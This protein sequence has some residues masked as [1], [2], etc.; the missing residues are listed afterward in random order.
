MV[1]DL[2][3]KPKI[4]VNVE[5]MPT[6]DGR[7]IL[8]DVGG[9]VDDVLVVNQLSAI[10][11]S[12]FDGTKSPSEIA[13]HVSFLVK[14]DI[15]E[16]EV[17]KIIE[18]LDSRGF[19]ETHNFSL[20]KSQKKAEFRALAEKPSKF[21]GKSFPAG[22]REA[23]EFFSSTMELFGTDQKDGRVFAVVSPHIE[24]LNGIKIYA[25]T[26][27]F[28]RNSLKN[29]DVFFIFG[30]SHAYSEYPIILTDKDFQTP[31]GTLRTD[32]DIVRAISNVVGDES[33]EDEIIH[34]TEHSVEFQAVFIKY[35]FPNSKIV[36]VLCSASWA[37]RQDGV[38]RYIETL[39]N[40][41]DKVI[42]GL[43]DF[44]LVAGAD[45][46]HIG[47]RFGDNPVNQYEISIVR[48]KDFISLQ[49]F[50]EN[51]QEGF[52]D[53]IMFDQNSRRVCGLA[54][55]YT[56]LGLTKNFKTYGKIIGWDVWVDETLSAV[57]F[58]SAYLGRND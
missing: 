48:L 23:E 58:G 22:G 32:K 12:M 5:I 4:R 8:R 1:I 21:A 52:L 40:I 55:I 46:A 17:K 57:S 24:I 13:K 14:A 41:Y 27:S 29:P 7:F 56:V 2:T 26:W 38:K 30:T 51:S 35:L 50:A 15:S 3:P 39:Y 47:T 34:K 18:T 36:P 54:P 16:A 31:F 28:L 44:I 19:L 10:I 43:K 49:K 37:Y 33:F 45:F 9:Y 42:S 53:S 11:I 6:G 25:K 20:L